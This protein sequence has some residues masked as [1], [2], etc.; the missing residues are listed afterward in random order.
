MPHPRAT[1]RSLIAGFALLTLPAPAHPAL[2]Q[3]TQAQP[4]Q[5]Q[6]SAPD[7]VRIAQALNAT[8]GLIAGGP[9]STDAR[10][11]ADIA[12]VLD[13]GD[14][15]RV[16]PILGGGAVQNIADLIYL[17]GVDVAIVPAETLTQ[18][19][20]HN[21]I[22][23]ERS[24]Q[25][26]AKLYQEEVHVLAR[27]DIASLNDLSGKPVNVGAPGTGSELT[28]GT[29]L[30]ALHIGAG[31]M[32]D[33]E[34]VAL[35]RLRRG[36]IAA[37]FVMGGKPVPLLQAVEPRTGLHFLPIPLTAPLVDTYLPTS[38]D[39]QYYPNL[40]PAGRPIDTVAIGV[41][42]VTLAT[43]P[44]TARAKR[45]NR[46]VDALFERLGQFRQPGFHSKWLEVNLSAQVPGWTRYPEAQTLLKKQDQAREASLRTAFDTYLN[47][48]GQ[49]TSGMSDE[50]RET[51]FRDFVRW[52]TQHS[53]P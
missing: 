44:D 22:P 42:L 53:R 28:A 35:D 32:H 37:M 10:I 52:R 50:Q 34:T 5:A 1:I 6:Q 21:A 16:L 7:P 25:Y 46:F 33:S 38:L 12:Q 45:V 9:G 43:A 51:L 15:L 23:G 11:A 40:I 14:K 4:A 30:D 19:M 47:E 24:I 29:L 26:I 41:V 27:A 3:P 48:T 2:A 8:V 31:I 13:D 17:K 36:D 20:E 18:T 39:H 49:T